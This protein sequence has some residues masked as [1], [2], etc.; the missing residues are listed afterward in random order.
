LIFSNLEAKNYHI[1]S[2]VNTN[3]ECKNSQLFNTL[4]GSFSK[5]INLAH[6]KLI[7]LFMMALCKARTVCFSKLSTCFDSPTK[8]DSCL[9][10]IQRF[11][12]KHSISQDLVAKF[13]FHLLPQKEKYR[14]AIDRTNWRFGSTDINIFMLA[15]VHDG[16]A[17]PLLF[18]MLPKKGTSNTQER[19]LLLQRYIDLFGIDSIDCL[20]ADREFVGERWIK[21]LNEE[22]DLTL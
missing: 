4:S 20:L 15:V 13:I 10:R 12:E 5:N 14:L 9:R 7:S 11:F 16:V 6:I 1:F 2:S 17:Y 22:P 8:A 19:I 18:S 21:W 3:H